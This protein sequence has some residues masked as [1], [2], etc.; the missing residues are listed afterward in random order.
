MADALAWRGALMRLTYVE[1]FAGAGGLSL[2]LDTAGWHCLGHAEVERHARA[3]LR[4]HWPDTPLHGDVAALTGQAIIDAAGGEVPLLLSGGSPCQDLSV[5]GKGAGL[6]GARSGLFHEQVRLWREI[7]STYCLW[8]NVL[9]A[10]S[11]NRGQDFA[12]VL[13]A[14]VGSP[15]AVPERGWRGG[16]GRVVGA[17][18]VAAWRVLD[19]RFFG[20]PQRRRRVFVLGARAGGVDPAQ[21]LFDPA[22][23]CGNAPSRRA[24]RQGRTVASR[25]A[26]PG[27][28]GGGAIAWDSNGLVSVETTGTVVSNVAHGGSFGVVGPIAWDAEMNPCIAASGTLAASG[29]NH[30]GVIGWDENKNAVSEV[31]G[32]LTSAGSRSPRGAVCV[33]KPSHFTRGKDGAPSSEVAPPLSADADKGDQGPVVV[34]DARGNGEGSVDTTLPGD[35]LN[36]VT[37]YTPIVVR[38]REGKPGGGKGPLVS[39]NVSLTLGTANDQVVLA[40]ASTQAGA[41]VVRDGEPSLTGLHDGP[42]II[43]APTLSPGAHPGGANG[44]DAPAIAAAILAA[45]DGEYS[46]PRRFLPIETERLMGWPSGWAEFGLDEAG[47]EYALKDTPR[48]RLCGNGVMTPVAAW[49]G[50]RLRECEEAASAAGAER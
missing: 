2:G 23:V 9:G 19:G 40:I 44:Q 39:V 49:I 29:A 3:V 36:R 32:T 15:V 10:L 42:P 14:F 6:A 30:Q 31:S 26:H 47:R 45:A 25:A 11:S 41:E 12:A 18:G 27:V 22:S 7:D 38:Q 35:H 28:A 21:V 48:Y 46:D 8:E 37:D 20:A 24:P 4:R 13:G 17:A 34:Y 5:A 43:V 33:F 50:W 16:G 1:L